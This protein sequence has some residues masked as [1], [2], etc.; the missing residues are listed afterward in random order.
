LLDNGCFVPDGTV[1]GEDPVED[2]KHYY[3]TEDG[4]VV[5]TRDML[6]QEWGY[7]PAGSVKHTHANDDVAD[8]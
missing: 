3:L 4:V 1:I 8:N 6:G 2:A 7:S 5:V